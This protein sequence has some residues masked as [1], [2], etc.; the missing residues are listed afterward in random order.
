[1]NT[2]FLLSLIL[3]FLESAYAELNPL[4]DPP[5][6]V[7]RKVKASDFL[8]EFILF[9][10]LTIYILVHWN[11]DRKNKENAR[12]WMRATLDIWED[13]FTLVGDGQ[14]HKLIRD[15]T[16]DYIF[17]ASGRKYVENVYAYL[18]LVARNDL[19]SYFVHQRQG[20]RLHDRVK[21]QVT[22]NAADLDSFIFAILPKKS[23]LDILK[24]RWDLNHFA[25]SLT[26]PGFPLKEF[27]SLYG[28]VPE[29]LDGLLSNKK[30]LSGL[31]GFIG[32]SL[33]SKELDKATFSSLEEWTLSDL[34]RNKP[35]KMEDLKNAKKVMTIVFRLPSLTLSTQELKPVL[36]EMSYFIMDV[37]D[38]LGESGRLSVEGK[39]KSKKIRIDVENSILKAQ[40]E[41]IKQKLYEKKIKEKKAKQEAVSKLSTEEQRKFDEKE[42][43]KEQKKA[44]KKMM[45]KGK[46][47]MK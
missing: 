6:P 23:V 30:I 2:P 10:V 26:V 25:K 9:L 11:G 33:D 41:E 31:Y 15:G 20:I 5:P 14:G 24:E 38:F 17:Y 35:E 16:R 47:V 32:L 42:R 3:G 1:M 22:L 13:N 4:Q 21:F 12:K 18:E 40:E 28:D 7:Y 27:Y 37:L 19:V 29:V 39:I 45:S 36:D 44:Q 43:K 34:P 8:V 46:V